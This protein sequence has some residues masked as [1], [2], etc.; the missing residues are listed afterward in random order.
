[1]CATK[2][3]N[4]EDEYGPGGCAYTNTG[5]QYT[6]DGLESGAYKLEFNGYIC[7]IPKTANGNAPRST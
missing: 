5:G 3:I 6:I 2:V 7:S 1:M 4:A